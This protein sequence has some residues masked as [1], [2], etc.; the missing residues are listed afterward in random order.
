MKLGSKNKTYSPTK[1][2]SDFVEDKGY[3]IY[4][5]PIKNSNFVKIDLIERIKD[6]KKI[7]IKPKIFV[8]KYRTISSFSVKDIMLI[9]FNQVSKLKPIK[10][11]YSNIK[12][13][14]KKSFFKK[15]TSKA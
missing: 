4:F 1:T 7:K 10:K 11:T 5:S 12:S 13:F 8:G 14:I 3:D 2:I 15:S 9:D 6:T